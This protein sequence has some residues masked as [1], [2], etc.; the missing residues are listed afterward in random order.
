MIVR[1][2]VI[3]P[4]FNYC[5]P[6][7]TFGSGGGEYCQLCKIRCNHCTIILLTKKY[8]WNCFFRQ[9]SWGRGLNLNYPQ[10]CIHSFC[11]RTAIL[12]F[13]L[14]VG[15]SDSESE[16]RGCFDRRGDSEPGR[17]GC[18]EIARTACGRTH[19]TRQSGHAP[20]RRDVCETSQL[21]E[22]RGNHLDN[23]S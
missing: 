3:R 8:G 14:L 17:Y 23:D 7:T 16:R 1:P 19:R 6:N 2:Y 5:S 11:S 22:P 12:L 4:W 9:I 10:L 21:A 13:P 20:P 18:A 15:C